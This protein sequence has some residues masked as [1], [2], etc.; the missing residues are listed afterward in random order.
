MK[1]LLAKALATLVAVLLSFSAASAA[2]IDVGVLSFDDT[3]TGHTFN[4]VNLTGPG[5][6]SGVETLLNFDVT[7]LVAF[8][9]GG[10]TLTIGNSLF[11]DDPASGNLDC[12]TPGLAPGGCNFEQV[13][14]IT[15]V[16]L[17]GTLSPTSGLIGL[18]P[19]FDG[20]ESAFSVLLTP[21]VGPY[22]TAGLDAVIIQA[23]LVE[24][25]TT[26]PEPST[27]M[28]LQLGMVALGGYRFRRKLQ[29]PRRPQASGE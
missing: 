29:F 27:A 14:S 18:P 5:S 16:S 9:E 28:L 6:L 22:L 20:I 11:T 13:N 2:T 4:I 15:G 8:L 12:T 26:V 17:T 1:G 25:P 7:S 21:S 19:G 3:G 24:T 10:G 23:T